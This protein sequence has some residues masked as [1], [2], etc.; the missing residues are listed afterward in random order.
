MRKDNWC[1]KSCMSVTWNKANLFYLHDCP[2]R[3]DVYSCVSTLSTPSSSLC[4]F[5]SAS[6]AL[7]STLHPGNNDD[8]LFL[9]KLESRQ[10]TTAIH[11]SDCC[12]AKFTQCFLRDSSVPQVLFCCCCIPLHAHFHLTKKCKL[13]R[14]SWWNRDGKGTCGNCFVQRETEKAE[15]HAE[16]GKPFFRKHV[17]LW[18]RESKFAWKRSPHIWSGII[19]HL[20]IWIQWTRVCQTKGT[21]TACLVAIDA[22]QYCPSRLLLL[23]FTSWT[24]NLDD[25]TSE[26]SS[27]EEETVIFSPPSAMVSWSCQAQIYANNIRQFW[28][29]VWLSVWMRSPQEAI[30]PWM[31]LRCYSSCVAITNYGHVLYK[32][33][34]VWARYL[35]SPFGAPLHQCCIKVALS[36][37][38]HCVGDMTLARRLQPSKRAD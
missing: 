38:T 5:A 30:S 34:G 29:Y 37:F 21:H 7:T 35:K 36:T 9:E 18:T 28:R 23:C 24:E 11:L 12:S 6:A 17:I 1:S 2:W 10:E 22:K 16:L 14:Q 4:I 19:T 27:D 32:W 20:S 31:L 33:W 25:L 8:W 15:T 26:L 13:K 3:D